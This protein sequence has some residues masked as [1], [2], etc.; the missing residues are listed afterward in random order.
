MQYNYKEKIQNV[1]KEMGKKNVDLFLAAPGSDMK[2]LIGYEHPQD[3]KALLLAIFRDGTSFVIHNRL[4]DIVP[5]RAPVDKML[6][7]AYEMQPMELFCREM[8]SS[9]IMVGR[10]AISGN[11]P[12]FFALEL[13]NLYPHAEFIQTEELTGPL[14]AVKGGPEMEATREAC[15][16]ADQALKICMD[17]GTEWVGKTERQLEARMMYEMGNL[18]LRHNAVSVCFGANAASCHHHPDD[19]VITFGKPLLIDFGA[20]YHF[21]NTDM[22]RMFFFGTA[23]EEYRRLYEMVREAERLGIE[24]AVCGNSL[25]ELDRIVREYLTQQGY[26]KYYIHRTSHG[27][28]IDCH[29]FPKIPYNGETEIKE[30]MIFSI[31][32][33][34]YFPGKY[35]I[36]IEDQI[37]M[38]NGRAQVL[39]SFTKDLIEINE[40]RCS[41][42]EAE[43]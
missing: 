16:R 40:G 4:H 12:A 10:I 25:Q 8:D 15:R 11:M 20:D 17:L 22:T 38:K 9:G 32:P 21:Y 23:D 33:G 36:R 19:T 1:V 28:G 24:A 42:D 13:K 29:D 41:M 34:V 27:V 43:K 14:R 31:E 18:G 37:M 5:E 26:G 3:D 6:V 2:Y 39:H 35:G 7:Y 30:G